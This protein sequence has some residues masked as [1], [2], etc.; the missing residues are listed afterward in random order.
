MQPSK[1]FV[2]NNNNA[3]DEL[4]EVSQSKVPMQL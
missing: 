3:N 4:R 2:Q 1:Q